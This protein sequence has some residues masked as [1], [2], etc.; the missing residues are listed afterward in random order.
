[1]RCRFIYMLFFISFCFSLPAQV[2][3]GFT[4]LLPHYV[5]LQFA[6]GIGFLSGGFGY[7]SKNKK[8]QAD[9]SYGYVPENV[10]GIEIHSVTG[11]L[12]WAPVS[13]RL[14]NTMQLDLLTTGLYINYAFGKQYF[15]FSPENYPLKYYGIPSALHMGIFIGEGIRWKRLALYYELGSTDRELSSF[16][17][18]ARSI[19]FT[20]IL[21]LGIGIRISV[22]KLQ[23]SA[24]K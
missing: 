23:G 10:G 1:M 5:K 21:N 11:K 12:T 13:R 24:R 19:N 20:D 17:T 4:K 14:K 16:I 2:R 7:E 22:G 18:N 9:L 15:L 8:F 3:K 6:G